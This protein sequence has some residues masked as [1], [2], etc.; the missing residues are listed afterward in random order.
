MIVHGA[1]EGRDVRR[2]RWITAA[3]VACATAVTFFV[4]GG[5]LLSDDWYFARLIAR[6]HIRSP[7]DAFGYVRDHTQYPP[8][9]AQLVVR[10]TP[11]DMLTRQYYLFCDQSAM[12][13]ATIV[14]K[15]GYP[16]ALID[17]VGP[18]G[19]SH[20]TVLGVR[21]DGTWTIYDVA[22]NLK[23]RAVG[24]SA[25]YQQTGAPYVF[26]AVYRPYPRI[27]QLLIQHNAYL[28]SF[29]LWLRRLS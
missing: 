2:T 13:L 14:H 15:M 25:R 11:R 17:L 27:Y 5:Y 9:G 21:Q 23:R 7:D 4:G 20:H 19:I 24:E 10:S 18:D 28:K 12:V 8:E 16:T 3:I 22:N 26:R 6:E 29:A 1:V